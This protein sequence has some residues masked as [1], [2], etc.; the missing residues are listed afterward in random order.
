[1]LAVAVGGL[2]ISGT[3][4]NSELQPANPLTFSFFLVNLRLKTQINVTNLKVKSK[5]VL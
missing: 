1:L 2:A 3:L 4:K 5:S